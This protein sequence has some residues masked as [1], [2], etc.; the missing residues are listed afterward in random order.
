MKN[1][2]RNVCITSLG[3]LIANSAVAASADDIFKDATDKGTELADAL[4]TFGLIF[5]TI[6]CVGVG[7]A[8]MGGYIAKKW[9]LSIA[10]GSLII[11]AAASISGFLLG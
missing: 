2:F 8:F 6:C 10:G 9:A 5:A 7:F 1:T 4:T 11:G 3:F